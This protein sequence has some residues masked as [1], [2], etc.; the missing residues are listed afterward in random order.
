MHLHDQTL[1]TGD[2][3]AMQERV[4]HVEELQPECQVKD[5]QIQQ[6]RIDVAYKDGQIE[7]LRRLL[8]VS[9]PSFSRR[10]FD[11]CSG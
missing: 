7:G 2:V 1:L 4:R 3:C 5:K 8:E 11:N 6:L 9:N 10:Q